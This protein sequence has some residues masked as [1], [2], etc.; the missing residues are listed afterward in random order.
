MPKTAEIKFPIVASIK[1]Q[2]N[3]LIAEVFMTEEDEKPAIFSK[4]FDSPNALKAARDYIQSIFSNGKAITL[5][6]WIAIDWK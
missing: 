4:R 1:A 2:G 6:Q 3:L 5:E